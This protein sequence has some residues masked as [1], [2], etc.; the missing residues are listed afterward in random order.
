MSET[1]RR[2]RVADGKATGKAAGAGRRAPAGA[3][4]LQ[5]TVT[6]A[7]RGAALKELARAGYARMSMEAI[8]RRAGV[9]KAAIYRRW[10]TKSALVVAVVSD[11]GADRVETPDTGS[12][13]GD[14]RAL[15]EAN[16][17]LL[18]H[19]M[20]SRILADLMAETRRDRR[21]EAAL[22][23]G[24][25]D[26]RRAKGVTMLERAIVRRE[27]PADL[28]RELALDFLGAPLYWRLIVTRGARPADYL[29]RL[30]DATLAALR[31]CS[32]KRA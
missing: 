8:A 30:C 3:A 28:D 19:P 23:S 32:H 7:I 12:L 10:P 24:V 14:V 6:A 16:L 9:G 18:R 21:L 31:A 11:V 27:L 17:R 22:R 1:A 25:Q 5:T 2:A 15:L 20:T 26:Q 4:V 13:R 29:D